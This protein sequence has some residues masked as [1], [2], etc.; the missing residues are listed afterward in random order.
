MRLCLSRVG[1]LYE[2]LPERDEMTPVGRNA[3]CPCGSGRK[4]KQ[5]C[6]AK[7]ASPLAGLTP[8]MRM[9][10]GVRF[11]PNAAGFLVIVHIWGDVAGHGDP[12]E[13]CALEV[14]PTEEAAMRYYKMVIRPALA[15]LMAHASRQGDAA[16]VHRKLA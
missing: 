8:G 16:V 7:G 2:L 4:H 14:F 15:R 9:K 12:T 10:G 13:W 3:P 11:D 5:C 1:S 6:G